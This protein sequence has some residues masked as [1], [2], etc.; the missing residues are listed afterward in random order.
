MNTTTNGG[1]TLGKAANPLLIDAARGILPAPDAEAEACGWASNVLDEARVMARTSIESIG[2]GRS[3]LKL[4]ESA[5]YGNSAQAALAARA[6]LAV[7]SPL[8]HHTLVRLVTIAMLVDLG[9]QSL[10]QMLRDA[11]G[12]VGKPAPEPADTPV[13]AGGAD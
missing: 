2:I 3:V 10:D 11:R 8:D 7:L 4:L 5:V 13:V 9:P 12:G 6:Y 1:G